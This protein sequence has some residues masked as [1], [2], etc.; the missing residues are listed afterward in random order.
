MP[1]EEFGSTSASD[2]NELVFANYSYCIPKM[3]ARSA[4]G[5]SGFQDANLLQKLP[6]IFKRLYSET[7]ILLSAKPHRFDSI[8]GLLGK[9]VANRSGIYPATWMFMIWPLT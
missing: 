2:R 4:V 1:P 3:S 5:S 6:R 8:R 7:A 9:L